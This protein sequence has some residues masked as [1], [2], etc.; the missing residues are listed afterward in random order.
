MDKVKNNWILKFILPESDF[1]RTIYD[2]GLVFGKEHNEKIGILKNEE[3]NLIKGF[4]N[5]SLYMLKK[6][7]GY[8]K[9]QAKG[10]IIKIN[11]LSRKNRSLK[12]VGWDRERI[13]FSILQDSSCYYKYF[14]V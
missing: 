8:F 12:I 10:T 1:V 2:N 9:Q 4:I 11:D 3:L 6:D 13:I 14:N 7:G 5:D